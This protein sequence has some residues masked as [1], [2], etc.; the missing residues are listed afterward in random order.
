MR[1]LI[2]IL[3]TIITGAG[4]VAAQDAATP[5]Q[6]Q[7]RGNNDAIAALAAMAKGEK[8]YDQA[9]VDAAIARLEE[10]AR[11]LPTLYPE[12]LK[13]APA[14]TRFSPSAKVWDDKAGFTAQIT[15]FATAVADAKAK[16]KNIDTLNV[17]VGAIGK[18]CGDCH[19]TF[20]VRNG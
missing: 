7:M 17:S 4:V 10:C 19:Q 11:K 14:T 5:G 6:S 1:L 3:A 8:P 9:A 20:R 2:L 13:D 15:G 12:S 16:V 18:Q